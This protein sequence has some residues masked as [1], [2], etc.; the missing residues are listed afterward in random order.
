MLERRGTGKIGIVVVAD[1][2]GADAMLASY[3]GRLVDEGY[4]VAIVGRWNVASDLD[5][6]DHKGL[7][8]VRRGKAGLAGVERLGGIGFGVG[9]L[10]A[11]LA[12][13]A[14]PGFSVAVD[15]GGRIVY[16]SIT[17]DKPAQPLDL[18]PGLRGGLLCHYGE[19]DPV[20]PPAHVEELNQRMAFRQLP[21]SL[22]LYPNCGRGFYDPQDEGY[23]LD[24][25]ELAWDDDSRVETI[26]V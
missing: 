2:Q 20:T 6:P 21:F 9:G 24:A 13:S 17:A 14:L 3:A 4:S 15:F 10:V 19:Q 25:A 16:P 18:L 7:A 8:A 5:L 12:A 1:V 11:R 26:H 22:Y 23:D